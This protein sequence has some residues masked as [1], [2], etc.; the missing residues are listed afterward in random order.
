[1]GPHSRRTCQ[2]GDAFCLLEMNVLW[3]K[4]CKSIPEEQQR[5]L[6]RCWRKWVQKQWRS[7]CSKTAI[8]VRLRFAT[9]NG[10]KN[11]TFWRNVLCSDETKIELFGPNDQHC[12][13]RK[14]G[15]ACKP[16]NIIPTVKNGGA[17]ETGTLHK[18]A[19]IMR[20][21]IMW[22]Y[23]SNISRHQSGSW[24]LVANGSSKWTMTPSILP[25]WWQ[26]GVR[27]TKSRYWNGHHKALT[28]ILPT[29]FL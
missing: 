2:E 8:K 4:M 3:Y 21:K 1:M 12:V 27:T 17:G 6:W 16:K 13:W 10:D 14:K 15:E 18:I 25:K 20:E 29:H 22:I 5:T 28:A 24:S 9:A 11:C 26:N 19:G 7:H 23:W